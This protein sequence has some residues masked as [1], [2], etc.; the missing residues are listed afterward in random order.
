MCNCVLIL[1][2]PQ[3]RKLVFGEKGKDSYNF[4]WNESFE[5]VNTPLLE[6]IEAGDFAF[7][8][9]QKIHLSNAKNL[10]IECGDSAF[11][12][13]TSIQMEHEDTVTLQY[14]YP[15]FMNYKR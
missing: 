7:Y 1:D 10:K 15:S 11:G 12:R 13:C 8:W 5:T 6:S 9:C 14:E 2:L 4:Y 3:L